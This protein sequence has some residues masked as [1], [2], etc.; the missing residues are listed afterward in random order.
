MANFSDTP[1]YRIGTR[2]LCLTDGDSVL[3]SW[4]QLA[5]LVITEV[6]IPGHVGLAELSLFHRDASLY[7]THKTAQVAPDTEVVDD[8]DL[9]LVISCSFR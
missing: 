3:R 7:R 5:W 2:L 4:I 8:R 6:L 1:C 9:R